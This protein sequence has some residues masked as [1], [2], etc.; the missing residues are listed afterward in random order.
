MFQT[1]GSSLGTQVARQASFVDAEP[2][3]SSN[4]TVPNAAVDIATHDTAA[5]SRR[6]SERDGDGYVHKRT[7]WIV[8]PPASASRVSQSLV[9]PAELA[10]CEARLEEVLT[11]VRPGDCALLLGLPAAATVDAAERLLAARVPTVIDLSSKPALYR[12]LGRQQWGLR[13]VSLEARCSS[14][15]QTLALRC[16]DVVV[17][18]TALVLLTP[19]LACFAVLIKMSSPG[20]VFFTTR[21]VGRDGR[22]FTWRKLR[23]MRIDRAE[24]EAARR[25]RFEAFVTGL[26]TPL[27]DATGHKIVDESRITRIGRLLRRHSLDELPQLWNVVRGEMTLVGPRPCLP[28]EYE[29]QAPWQRLRFR[30]T[31]GL[32][33]PWQAYGRSRVTFDDMV[34]MDYCYSHAR[35]FWLDLRVILRT[36]AVVVRGDG[37]K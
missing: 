36:A 28:Y 17:A 21:V 19:L 20:P 35:S 12:S 37:G 31:P 9:P 16:R 22:V 4:P 3:C 23:S 14:R 10:L 27:P 24:D 18:G 7:I 33:G 5:G 26:Y 6:S 29:L 13:C 32:T 11:S 30:V 1:S 8:K 2:T 25:Q 15:A 34:L